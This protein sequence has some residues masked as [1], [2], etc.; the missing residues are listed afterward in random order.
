M[1]FHSPS[2][3]QEPLV[4]EL[5][6]ELDPELPLPEDGAGAG[7]ADEEAGSGAVVV[8]GSGD[9]ADELAGAGSAEGVLEG[10]PAAADEEPDEPEEPEEPGLVSEPETVSPEPANV[11]VPLQ[12]ASPLGWRFSGAPSYE[13]TSPG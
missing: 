5:E 11:G 8:L 3:L 7:S 12:A 10:A 6:P 13:I 1:Q 4:P 9:A 2:G